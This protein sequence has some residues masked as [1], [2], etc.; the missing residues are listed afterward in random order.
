MSLFDGFDIG[1]FE[2]EISVAF[3]LDRAGGIIVP[4]TKP[5]APKTMIEGIVLIVVG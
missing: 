1:S 2:Y 3:G 5:E 4:P